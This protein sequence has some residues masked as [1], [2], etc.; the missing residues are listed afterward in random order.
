MIRPDGSDA[1]QLTHGEGSNEDPTWSPDGRMLAF[2]STRSGGSAI[3]V[4]Q[5]NGTGVRRLTRNG[6]GQE[7]PDWSPRP[8]GR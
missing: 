6:S 1:R 7:L 8:S 5:A 4:L 2:S 3:W